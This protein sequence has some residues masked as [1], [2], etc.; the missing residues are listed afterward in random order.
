M[1]A[2]TDT[3]KVESFNLRY[4]NQDNVINAGL[5]RCEVV[6]SHIQSVKPDIL[7]LQEALAHQFSGCSE[8]QALVLPGIVQ[9]GS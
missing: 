4:D 2:G 8:Y 6:I 9:P 1:V 5:K 3:L 7:A